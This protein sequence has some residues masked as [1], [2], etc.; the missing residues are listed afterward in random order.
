MISN[1][2]QSMGQSVCFND[3][4]FHNQGNNQPET[5]QCFILIL[6]FLIFGGISFT[7]LRFTSF[8]LVICPLGQIV[9]FFF[10]ISFRFILFNCNI[11]PYDLIFSQTI[12]NFS[13]NSYLK[14]RIKNRDLD[15]DS[16]DA[17]FFLSFLRWYR[18]EETSG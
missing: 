4:I 9:Q 8:G 14:G 7:H 5:Y 12:S 16:S 11:F 3:C 18:K 15:C 10:L 17:I 13:C 2:R 1:L 6:F